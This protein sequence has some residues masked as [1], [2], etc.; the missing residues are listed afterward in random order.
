MILLTEGV[1]IIAVYPVEYEVDIETERLF[2]F[3]EQLI[4]P[5]EYFLNVLYYQDLHEC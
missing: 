2:I 3:I 5:T 4:Q 1:P